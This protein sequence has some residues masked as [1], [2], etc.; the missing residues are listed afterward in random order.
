[1]ETFNFEAKLQGCLEGQSQS[2]S[3]D[4]MTLYF[5]LITIVNDLDSLSAQTY[6][7]S[8][9]AIKADSSIRKVI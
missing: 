9:E 2:C 8:D 3:Q 5:A 7:R 1:M 4:E 6:L